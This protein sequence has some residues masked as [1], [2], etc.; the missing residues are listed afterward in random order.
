M[1]NSKKEIRLL[2]IYAFLQ[3]LWCAWLLYRASIVQPWNPLERS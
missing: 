1:S 3:L 2:V